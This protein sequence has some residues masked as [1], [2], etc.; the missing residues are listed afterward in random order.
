MM[1]ITVKVNPH[2]GKEPAAVVRER[3]KELR[4]EIGEHAPVEEVFPG[5][6]SGN[7]AG[8]VI[9]RLPHDLSEE[10]VEAVLKA[11][12]ADKDIQYAEPAIPRTHR[13]RR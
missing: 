13:L 3:L 9:V 4:P 10:D 7:R 11:L 6:K 5:L 2:G 8:M 12:R 1:Q